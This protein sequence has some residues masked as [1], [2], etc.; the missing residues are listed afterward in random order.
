MANK[1][2]AKLKEA[3]RALLQGQLDDAR[4]LLADSELRRSPPGQILAERVVDRI[5]HQAESHLRR[6]DSSAAWNT[7]NDARLLAPEAKSLQQFREKMIAAALDEIETL[8]ANNDPEAALAKLNKLHQ[9]NV[10]GGRAATLRQVALKASR[11][12]RQQRFGKFEEAANNWN[13]AKKLRE[14]MN[15]FAEFATLCRSKAL[16]GKQLFERLQAAMHS[17]DWQGALEAA[18]RLLQLAPQHSLAREARQE[19]WEHVSAD[20]TESQRK[21]RTA[22]WRRGKNHSDEQQA[23]PCEFPQRQTPSRLIQQR[24]AQTLAVTGVGKCENRRFQLWIDAVGGYLVCLGQEVVL[25]Q[26]VPGATTDIPIFG[27]LSHQHA[28]IRRDGEGYILTPQAIVAVEGRR[29]DGPSFLTDGDEILLGESVR[30]R[31]RRPHPLSASAWLEPLSGH[32]TQPAGDAVLLM[33]E[34][35]VLGRKLQ[36]H[37]VC[38]DWKNEVILFRQGDRI[39]CRSGGPFEIDG[40]LHEDEG[41]L[42]HVSNVCGEDFSLSVEEI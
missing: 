24:I 35:I 27:D 38:R 40:Q 18:D 34:S 10:A 37:V 26:A 4:G 15:V 8:L 1:P 39:H 12:Q 30:F 19:A 3:E 23:P 28:T 42:G 41:R 13:A 31:F 29:L 33:A 16:E 20:L 25:G 2:Q 36:S 14:D 5:A 17:R 32:R 21:A 11:A 7:L 22:S 6:G 9:R